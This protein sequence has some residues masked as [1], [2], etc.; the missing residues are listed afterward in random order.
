MHIFIYIFVTACEMANEGEASHILV[1]VEEQ[2]Q[3]VQQERVNQPNPTDR[4][5]EA[6][7]WLTEQNARLLELQA[8][9]V[10][11]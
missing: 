4:M 10:G 7:V 11:R 1:S 6:I 5:M 8:V 9:Q 2:K 3:E